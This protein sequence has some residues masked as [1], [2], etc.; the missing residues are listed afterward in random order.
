[1]VSLPTTRER[2]DPRTYLQANQSLFPVSV[3]RHGRPMFLKVRV[4]DFGEGWRLSAK[5]M[6]NPRPK[7][8]EQPSSNL[9]FS[10]SIKP[11]EHLAF[12]SSSFMRRVRVQLR[13]RGDCRQEN[14]STQRLEELAE[15]RNSRGLPQAVGPFARSESG[16]YSASLAM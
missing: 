7:K 16:D 14:R 8:D 10:R 11:N 3:I 4:I 1:M 9:P 2:P 6:V 15:D 12:A 5:E 13:E